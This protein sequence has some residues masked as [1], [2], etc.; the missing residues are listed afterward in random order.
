MPNETRRSAPSLAIA[1]CVVAA[2]S[3][4]AGLAAA[5]SRPVLLAD[6]ERAPEVLEV[7]T[8]GHRGVGDLVFFVRNTQTRGEEPWR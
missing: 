3:A 8:S 2:V 5:Q 4:L 7:D 1:L 6:L